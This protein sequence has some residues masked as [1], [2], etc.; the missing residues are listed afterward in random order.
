MTRTDI[1]A[2]SVVPCSTVGVG[3]LYGMCDP[4]RRCS[5]SEDK[6][7]NVAFTVAHELGH[8]LGIYHDGDGNSCSDSSGVFPHVMS[9][10]WLLRNK[11]GSM[12]WSE[13]SKKSLKAFLKSKE[14]KCLRHRVTNKKLDLPGD[15]PGVRYSA[16]DQCRLQYGNRA[17][18]CSKY[19]SR[20]CQV[21][22]CEIQGES[23]CRS[24]LNPPARG[25]A[26]GR[27]KWCMYGSCVAN[28]L[29]PLRRDG[30]W[31]SWSRWS[32]CSRS[33]GTGVSSISR[34][35]NN[36]RP[37]YGGRYCTGEDEMHKL[38]NVKP[39]PKESLDF[40]VVQCSKFNNKRYRAKV[41]RSWLPMISD[42][43]PCV[44]FCRPK[45]LTHRF[46]AK[47][48]DSVVDG[49]PCRA[50]S[51]DICI[52]GKCHSVGCDN[53]L[54]SG[55]KEDKCGVCNGNGT[56]CYTVEG[57]FNQLA[58]RGYVEAALIPKGAR[59]INVNE[60]KPC[61]SFLALRSQTDRYYING[62]RKIQLPGMFE[63]EGTIFKYTRRGTWERLVAKGPTTTP[64][65]IMVLYNGFN[66][67]VKYQYTLPI[68]MSKTTIDKKQLQLPEPTYGWV[69]GGWGPCSA[70]CDGG[71][72]KS[73]QMRCVSFYR[74]KID[75]VENFYCKE[76]TKPRT[77]ERVCNVHK[78]PIWWHASP[79]SPCV[80]TCGAGIQKR[81]V[82][83]KQKHPNGTVTLAPSRLCTKDKPSKIRNCINKA[84]HMK[85]RV[86]RWTRCYAVCGV[87]IRRRWV[88]CPRK[89]LCLASSKPLSKKPCYTRPCVEWATGGWTK[90]STRCGKGFQRRSVLCR[91]IVTGIAS[92]NCS[93]RQRPADVK[94]CLIKPCK[95]PV[96]RRRCKK[97]RYNN[98]QCQS[99]LKFKLCHNKAWYSLCCK[100]CERI[101]P[102]R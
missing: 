16:D 32:P 18:H 11:H 40:R 100:T 91:H 19:K 76:A 33:C 7:L 31:S 79:W 95:V 71:I 92:K 93:K 29:I 66:L 17:R 86:G 45:G 60:V 41:Y 73:L 44:L 13:C 43:Q 6:G 75:F 27:D 67:G 30:G 2:D 57:H 23:L 34:K 35:C 90:C 21:L 36:P 64:F 3:F 4:N 55:A 59:N 88:K 87:G 69:H 83:C 101:A 68:N 12:K 70:H 63:A 14:S 56:T 82:K 22:W 39:C 5:V 97:D 10:R 50:D 99:V 42:R 47:L 80:T 102:P 20:L 72:R 1:C 61:T 9:P 81:T 48:A 49:T 94:A 51:Q 15:L 53:Q 28:T 62:N 77:E 89:N 25:T 38:C 65:H 98:D 84:C 85:W 52:N 74:G 46:S 24:K 58:G 26:C 8:N 37:Q 54:G 96:R 78:C